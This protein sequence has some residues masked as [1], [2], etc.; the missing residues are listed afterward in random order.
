M[1]ASQ[2]ICRLPDEVQNYAKDV[3]GETESSRRY[4]LEELKK[5][6]DDNPHLHVRLEEKFLLPFLRVSKF[7]LEKAKRKLTNFYT[8]RRDRKEWFTNRN[9]RLSQI[10]ELT[11]MG[12]FLVL[13][14]T[15]ENQIIVI[16]KPTIHDPKIYHLDDVIKSGLMVLD[17]AVMEEELAQIYGVIAIIDMVNVGFGHLKY[18]TPTRIKN[19]VNAWQ[20]FHCRPQRIE[21][22]NAPTF[23][24]VVLDIFKKFMTMKLKQRTHICYD[25]FSSLAKFVDKEILP[26][27]Y[28]GVEGSLTELG[29]YWSEKLVSYSEWFAEDEKFK[30]EVETNKSNWFTLNRSKP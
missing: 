9:P 28:G 25:G 18:L 21:F 10:Q 13:K 26:E 12:S 15:F 7:D 30:A 8:M 5:W 14:K 24:N 2:Y 16:V 20:N 6:A 27:E 23:I 4:G 19:L 17:V 1:S 11:K 29:E 22:V 3:L